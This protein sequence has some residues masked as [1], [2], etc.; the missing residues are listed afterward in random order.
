MFVGGKLISLA[1]VCCVGGCALAPELPPDSA[2]SIR[3][4]I[5]RVQCELA[6]A[7]S[8]LRTDSRL[9]DWDAGFT[10]D[11]K[12]QTS[13]EGSLGTET[14]ITTVSRVTSAVLWSVTPSANLSIAGSSARSSTTEFKTPMKKIKPSTVRS[15]IEKGGPTGPTRWAFEGNLGIGEWLKRMDENT[16]KDDISRTTGFSYGLEFTL[17]AE[18]GGRVQIALVGSNSGIG[19]R[20]SNEETHRIVAAFAPPDEPQVID[21][22]IV[23]DGR[24]LVEQRVVPPGPGAP[25]VKLENLMQQQLL[26]LQLQ[27]LR[28]VQ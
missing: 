15:C 10:L 24:E 26:K 1:A 14:L 22:R 17:K 13:S 20:I 9:R 4:L 23:K 25:N 7:H 28:I 2:L 18:A 19:P 5:D 12:V 6:L 21:V 11:L 8:T 16:Q 27:N 3:D